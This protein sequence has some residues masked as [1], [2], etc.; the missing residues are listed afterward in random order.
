MRRIKDLIGVPFS[1]LNCHG[2][3]SKALKHWYPDAVL[4][5]DPNGGN[6]QWERV[7]TPE[8]GCVITMRLDPMRPDLVQHVGLYIG[9]N[10][11]LQTTEK[12]NA[13]LIRMDDRFWKNKIEGIYKWTNGK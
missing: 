9:D 13:H 11:V 10:Y 7:E 12:M 3:V 4:P 1:E 6:G 8:E 5:T 2:L